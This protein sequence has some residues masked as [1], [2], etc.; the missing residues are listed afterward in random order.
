MKI[1]SLDTSSEFMSLGLKIDEDF[2][3]VNIHAGQTHSELVLPEIKK[4]LERCQLTT[5]DL[6]AVAFGRG[7][8]SFTGI[9]IACGI[10]YGL[11]YG[12]SIPV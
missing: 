5:K 10:A 7:P 3:S 2:Y 9:R 4:L 11:G 8:G 1:L 6:D 12:S